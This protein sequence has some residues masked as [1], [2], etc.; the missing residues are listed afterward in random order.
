MRKV[1]R[2]LFFLV[3]LTI[4]VGYWAYFRFMSV[5][6]VRCL[7]Q[8]GVCSRAILDNIETIPTD[9]LLG[10]KGKLVRKLSENELISSFSIT[11]V[12]PWNYR[13][14]LV[15]AKADLVLDT[16]EG[17]S[18]VLLTRTGQKVGETEESVL[19][20]IKLMDGVE[21]GDY[22]IVAGLIREMSVNQGI[23]EGVI[24][25]EG[26]IIVMPD[27]IKLIYPVKGD[28]DVLLGATSAVLSW[29]NSEKEQFRIGNE[30]EGVREVD[31]R[32]NNPVLR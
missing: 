5:G 7:S 3:F 32:F 14:D 6:R 29:L 9:S 19:P 26:L 17:S 12:F 15:E 23:M 4:P 27:G 16:G 24:N 30:L 8:Y 28:L 10:Y 13:V 22:S 1:K 2:V 25:S 18:L 21:L 31:F 20:K 11:F